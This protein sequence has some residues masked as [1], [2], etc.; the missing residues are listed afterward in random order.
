MNP[1]A[2]PHESKSSGLGHSNSCRVLLVSASLEVANQFQ[3]EL[4]WQSELQLVAHTQCSQ[5]ARDQLKLLT[6]DVAI[7]DLRLMDAELELAL[8]GLLPVP[9]TPT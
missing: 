9:L 1:V 3:R 2:H 8:F 4:A 6:P 7:V 5:S